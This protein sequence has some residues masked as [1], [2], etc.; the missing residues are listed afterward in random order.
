MQIHFYP[1]EKELMRKY[2]D[3]YRKKTGDNYSVFYIMS[4]LSVNYE[5]NLEKD[6]KAIMKQ[7]IRE[8]EEQQAREGGYKQ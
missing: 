1:Q 3:D 5:R 4:L 6:L 7:K 8:F 2:A